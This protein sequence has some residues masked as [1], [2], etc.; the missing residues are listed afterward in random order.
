MPESRPVSQSGGRRG[1]IRLLSTGPIHVDGNLPLEVGKPL[2]VM[3]VAD[4]ERL[5]GNR[6]AC[7]VRC[8][9]VPEEVDDTGIC[10]GL[11][12]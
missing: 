2:E 1:T 9:D 5:M 3:P 12:R 6:C 7:H 10:K 8:G 11:P 4:H